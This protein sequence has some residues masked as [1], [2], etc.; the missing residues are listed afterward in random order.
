M[1]LS[2]EVMT[3]GAENQLH[4]YDDLLKLFD[5]IA[6]EIQEGKRRVRRLSEAAR[7]ARNERTERDA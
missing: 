2:R 7:T 5:V 1:D 4:E 3:M 6:A